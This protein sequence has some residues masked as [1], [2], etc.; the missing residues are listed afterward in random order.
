M[1]AALHPA[2]AAE[3]LLDRLERL[4]AVQAEALSAGD[5]D[6]LLAALGEKQSALDAADLPDLL[7]AAGPT[8]APSLTARI[9]ALLKADGEA[10][11]LATARRDELA[12]ELSALGSASAAQ[13]AYGG[14]ADPPSSPRRLDVAG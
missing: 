13:G 7:R 2:D 6:R 12:G 3:R 9:E 1:T 5:D 4:T 11:A 14:T 8:R 10:L